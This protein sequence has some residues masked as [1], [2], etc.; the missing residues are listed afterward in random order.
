MNLGVL[1]V[2]FSDRS[3][4][5]TLKYLAGLGIDTLE[6]GCGGF[7]G[8]AHC[9]PEI[10][11]NDP[12]AL[13]DY[14]ALLNNYGMKIAALSAHGNAVHP[15]KATAATAHD[16]FMKACML[17]EKLDVDTVVTFSGCPGDS[18]NAKYPNWVTCPWPDDFLKIKQWQWEEVLIPYW[19]KTVKQAG[20]YG[21]KRIAFEM[22]PGFCVY[23]PETMLALRAAVGD[24]LGA[25][26][27]PS[28]L[29][30][31]GIDPVEAIY[32]LKGAIYH[33]HAKDTKVN[34]RNTRVNGVLDTKHFSQEPDRSWLFRTVGYGHGEDTWREIV[35]ALRLT[36]YDR[37]MAIEHEDSLMTNTE[38][39]EKAVELLKRVI[40][41]QPKPGGMWWA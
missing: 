33:F 32:A 6:I 27:D 12:K 2:L 5:D 41:F 16:H 21:I 36:G 13:A 35:T 4:E 24:E 10:L 29:W 23:N 8:R 34:E 22:H 25:N 17:A 20:E 37:T 1:T 7:P 30:W 9:D 19:K 38:G 28:H 18:E 11:L 3:L 26:F 15:D 40:M 31:Q 14:K 39:L